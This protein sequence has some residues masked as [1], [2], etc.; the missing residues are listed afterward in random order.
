[1][2]DYLI[3]MDTGEQFL[4]HHGVQGMKWGKWNAETAARYA[5]GARSN[6]TIKMTSKA[7]QH[8]AKVNEYR[9]RRDRAGA[10]MDRISIKQDRNPNYQ[11]SNRER[12]KY[13]AAKNEYI[14]SSDNLDKH[15]KKEAKHNV[16]AYKS[17]VKDAGGSPDRK[18][19]RDLK[20]GRISLDDAKAR[21]EA[22]VNE[23]LKNGPDRLSNKEVLGERNKIGVPPQSKLN[24]KVR[25][26]DTYKNKMSYL[27]EIMKDYDVNNKT[28]RYDVEEFRRAAED[29]RQIYNNSFRYAKN[30]KEREF[31]R[32]ATIEAVAERDYFDE[33]L[34]KS[35]RINQ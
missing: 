6:R 14:R 24:E 25:Q 35:N 33:W 7:E 17:D 26:S 23:V 1:M 21:T 32:K 15:L 27:K 12:K 10:E 19:V 18:T 11:Y 16:K 34:K 9:N 30:D 13:S 28:D 22:K 20:K 2:P 8:R 29:D 3:T 5:G 31:W 4:A